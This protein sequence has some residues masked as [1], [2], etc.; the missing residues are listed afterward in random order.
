MVP[1][2][3][4]QNV[5]LDWFST[6]AGS[7]LSREEDHFSMHTQLDKAFIMDYYCRELFIHMSFIR[8]EQLTENIEQRKWEAHAMRIL[9]IFRRV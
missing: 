6:K 9:I 4:M 3:K 5:D 7:F 8:T 2:H 1:I